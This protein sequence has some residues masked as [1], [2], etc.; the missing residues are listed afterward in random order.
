M[1]SLIIPSNNRPRFLRRAVI[2]WSKQNFN[3]IICDGSDESQ[4]E[5]ME[6][7]AGENIKYIYSKTALPNR[8]KLASRALKTKYC[9]FIPDDEF[10]VPS[11]LHECVSFLDLNPDYVATCG[12]AASFCFKDAQVMGCP[13]YT[14]WIGRELSSDS[15]KERVFEHMSSYANNL[16]ISVVRS[17]LWKY[18]AELYSSRDFPIYALFEL[19]MNTILAYAGKSKVLG[20]L[21]YLRSKDEC[22]PIRNNIPSLNFKNTLYS[23]W[24]DKNR[25]SLKQE[26]LSFMADAIKEIPGTSFD[27]CDEMEIAEGAF[28][29]Y[30]FSINR[31]SSM[32]GK[33]V[34][35]VKRCIPKFIINYIKSFSKK[36]FAFK[37]MLAYLHDLSESGITVQCE[38]VKLICDDIQRF[39]DDSYS[40][41]CKDDV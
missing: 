39:Y 21:M 23:F 31:R 9:S 36:N 7:N 35:A 20:T 6:A 29:S 40:L 1:L 26:F 28:D 41:P 38:E 12:V 16:T 24:N 14:N 10:F 8:L 17:N 11:A 34:D 19:Q 32:H 22:E 3:V 37:P 2:Y 25:V 18:V 27:S 4:H 15:P 13:K 33:L 5:W 30:C